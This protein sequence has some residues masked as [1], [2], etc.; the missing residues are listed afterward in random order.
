DWDGPP[1]EAFSLWEQIEPRIG[2]GALRVQVRGGVYIRLLERHTAD[3]LACARPERL[4]ELVVVLASLSGRPSEEGLAAGR[5]LV[6]A[7]LAVGRWRD[8]LASGLAAALAAVPAEDGPPVGLACLG[9]VRRLWP[10]PPP[11]DAGLP[12]SDAA[13]LSDEDRADAFWR[14]L[15]VADSPA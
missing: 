11:A 9:V 1:A 6:R 8:P 2:D 15:L 5:R 13:P 14:C 7:R 10:A 12:S 4:P 3:E